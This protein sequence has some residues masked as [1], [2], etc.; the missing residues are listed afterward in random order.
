MTTEEFSNEFDTL[1][2]SHSMLNKFNV[3]ENPMNIVLDEYEK[4]ILLTKA[5]EDIVISFYNGKNPYGDSFEKTEEIRRYLSDLVKTY[6]TSEKKS[7]DNGL[8]DKSVFFSLPDDLWFIT[9]ESVHLDDENL[10][11]FNNRDVPVVPVT[12]DDFFRI[13]NNPFR[14]A[15]KRRALR[16]DNDNKTVEIISD[17]NISSYL[18]RY[19]VEPNPIILTD[20]P[21]GLSINKIST[22]TECTLNPALHRMILEEAVKAAILMKVPSAG[23]KDK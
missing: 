20:L 9:Y 12:Q 23:I 5:Q 22:K 8:S 7:S 15:G 21:D 18:V 13:L 3:G 16:L 19:I 10:G 1:L 4:S 11:C 2:N 14:N 17:Y 6:I